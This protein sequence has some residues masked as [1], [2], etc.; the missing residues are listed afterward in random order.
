MK[1]FSAS[2]KGVPFR[3]PEEASDADIDNLF[4]SLNLNELVTP[5]DCIDDLR[6]R[7]KLSPLSPLLPSKNIFVF[8]KKN[9][10]VKIFNFVYLLNEV[11]KIWN[12]SSLTRPST[13]S[14]WHALCKSFQEV[15]KTETNTVIED[16]KRSWSIDPFK[17][18]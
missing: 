15:F 16:M 1:S 8:S 17:P 7:L 12:I 2:L 13:L 5:Y 14:W 18:C 9:S 6:K 11:P 3:V 10:A 4:K